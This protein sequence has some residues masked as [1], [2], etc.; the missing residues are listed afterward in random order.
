[1][2]VL[3]VEDDPA[4]MSYLEVLMKK[5][6]HDYRKAS[7][8]KSGLKMFHEFA[9]DIVLSD[10]NM[11]HMTGLEMVERIRQAQPGV[12]I[13]ML[14]AYNSE[15]YVI[16]AMKVGANNYL[17]KPV[18]R[19]SLISL[20]RKYDKLIHARLVKSSICSYQSEHL[21]SLCFDTNLEIIPSVVNY[22]VQET[23]ELFNEEEKLDIKLG[24]GELILNAVEHGNM[25]ISYDEKN[26][27]IEADRLQD[28]Y[29]QKLEAIK[30]TD[31][32]VEVVYSEKEGKSQWV[33]KDQ[34]DGFDPSKIPNPISPDGIMRL[35]G[36]GIFICKFQFDEM[37]YLGKGNIVRVIKNI[38]KKQC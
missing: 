4:S 35:H 6:G 27:A 12:I 7:D 5:E 14:T 22:L 23:A 24:L 28:L 16:A 1:M 13:I 29:Q 34:G 31:S 18:S 10:I 2:K 3:L 11:S 26:A 20:L 15:E 9:P 36:R 21:F 19:N 30:C 17:K 38:K 33:I 37:E 32:Y 25:R 8:G